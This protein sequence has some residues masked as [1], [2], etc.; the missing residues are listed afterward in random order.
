MI[1][2]LDLAGNIIYPEVM[3]L[4]SV[5]LTIVQGGCY[6]QVIQ[7]VLG[8]ALNKKVGWWFERFFIFTP[9]P[10]MMIQFHY[11]PKNI[12]STSPEKHEKNWDRL[13]R[14][15]AVFRGL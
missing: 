12:T 10:G 5:I 9:I 6:P 13:V 1:H 7:C 2:S 8:F 11:T 4:P 15:L 14:A 3:G